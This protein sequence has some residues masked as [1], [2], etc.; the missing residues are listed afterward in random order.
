MLFT[1]G[2]LNFTLKAKALR[3]K[4]SK[5][6][7]MSV[8]ETNQNNLLCPWLPSLQIPTKESGFPGSPLSPQKAED[9]II[10]FESSQLPSPLFS[11]SIFICTFLQIV[12]NSKT[13]TPW[14][15][16]GEE[17]VTEFQDSVYT[18]GF[19][20]HTRHTVQTD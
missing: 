13:V 8:R 10:P 1:F 7:L 16:M 9:N 4:S 11:V 6:T 15:A 18:E 17:H 3:T 14:V 5:Q 12:L 19:I 2:E 20:T